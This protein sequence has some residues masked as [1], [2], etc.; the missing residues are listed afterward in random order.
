MDIASL[1][2]ED[3]LE[4]ERGRKRRQRFKSF[5]R[6]SEAGKECGETGKECGRTRKQEEGKKKATLEELLVS[7]SEAG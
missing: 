7:R 5:L 3:M 2:E 4:K 6:T 1:S